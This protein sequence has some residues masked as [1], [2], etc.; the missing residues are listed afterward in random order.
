MNVL[1][2]QQDGEPPEPVV[3]NAPP[4]SPQT[5]LRGPQPF[6]PLPMREAP[7]SPDEYS[8]EQSGP[9]SEPP[10]ETE[11]FFSRLKWL[12]LRHYS[13]DGRNAGLGIPLVGT[14]WLNRPYYV[15][16]DLGT[17]WMT[18]RVQPDVTR[19][20]DTY[21]GIY[22]GWDWDYYWGTEFAIQRA[23]PELI[24]EQVPNASRGDR[25]MIYTANM[26][27]YPW[28]DSFYR[29]YWRVGIGEMDIDYP[30]DNGQ[31]RDESLW[32]FP[33]GV[34]IKYPVRRWLAFRAEVTDE[35]GLGNSGVATQHDITLT[36]ALEWRFGAHP[37]SYWPWNPSRHI[38]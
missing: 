31:R 21:G 27:Y 6:D 7:S 37:R 10:T 18:D 13:T 4:Q 14:S 32:V 9:E 34:G 20:T 35:L 19:D 1:P 33:I 26:M 11:S 22:A 25:M 16:A 24:N 28:G 15:G 8:T 36:F 12:G 38:W 29:P 2:P 30:M 17:V 3:K 5:P 23:T